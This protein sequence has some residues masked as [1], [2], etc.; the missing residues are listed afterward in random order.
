MKRAFKH[1]NYA[2][3][4]ARAASLDPVGRLVYR[5]NLLGSDGRITNSGGGNT[6]SKLLEDDPLSGRRVEVLWVKGS[7]GDLRTSTRENFSSLYQEKLVGLRGAYASRPDRGLKS[8]AEDDM[9]AMYAHATFNL[10]P[11][12]PSIDTPLHAFL[13]GRHVDHMHPNAVIAV[14]ASAG[15]ERLTGEIFGGE[16]AYVPWVRPGFELGLMM[17]DI[18]R[19]SPNIRAIMMGQHGFIS[20]ADDDEECYA[21]TLG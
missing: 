15:C 11:R 16:M 8:P 7:G 2:W 12:A 5:S 9:V 18:V 3:D 4:G 20:W 13:P 10:N 1:V 6:S 14:A 19:R 21:A 17:Q